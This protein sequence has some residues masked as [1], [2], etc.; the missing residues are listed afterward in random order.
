MKIYADVNIEPTTDELVDLF[1]EKE[2]DGRARFFYELF[3][4]HGW[5]EDLLVDNIYDYMNEVD[6][7]INKLESMAHLLRRKYRR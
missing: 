6:V 2:A 3:V 1:L 5:D 4:N 7:M